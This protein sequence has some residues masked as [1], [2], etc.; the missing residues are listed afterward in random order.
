MLDS[1]TAAS[2]MIA[3]EYTLVSLPGI[4]P[5]DPQSVQDLRT[6]V[7]LQ[8]QG[9]PVIFDARTPQLSLALAFAS[10]YAVATQVLMRLEDGRLVLLFDHETRELMQ[11]EQ[12]DETIW[13]EI[14][15]LKNKITSVQSIAMPTPELLLD[16]ATIWSRIKESNDI[17]VRTK[18]FLKAIPSLIS[19][20]MT[21]RMFG[22]IPALPL[23]AVLYLVRSGAYTV[24]YTNDLGISVT[25]FD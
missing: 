17:V 20:C 9:D 14:L 11:S 1:Q 7:T 2:P 16:L 24:E 6:Q 3:A 25:L 19:P 8:A 21:L 13:A 18:L 22:D 15:K 12:V 4:N 10:A 5:L 23:T